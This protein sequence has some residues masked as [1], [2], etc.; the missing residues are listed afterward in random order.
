MLRN[1]SR[2]VVRSVVQSNARQRER[3]TVSRVLGKAFSLRFA[4]HG[5]TRAQV[6][7]QCHALMQTWADSERLSMNTAFLLLAQYSGKAVIPV[8]TVV[9]DYFPHLSTDKFIRKVAVGEIKIPMVRIEGS[10]QNTAKG[11]HLNDLAAYIDERR[12][13]AMKECRQLRAAGIAAQT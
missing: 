13:A 9:R 10:T 8:E 3:A 6:L 1:P 5:P 2:Q 4:G 12:E 7:D 11:I